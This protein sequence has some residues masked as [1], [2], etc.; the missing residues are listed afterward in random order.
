MMPDFEKGGYI[1]VP[2]EE[3]EYKLAIIARIRKK[4]NLPVFVIDYA[5]SGDKKTIAECLR[6]NRRLGFYPYIAEK[7]L[8][9]IYEN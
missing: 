6:E 7:E 8:D 4:R 5:D 2:A 3:R 1:K 9:A